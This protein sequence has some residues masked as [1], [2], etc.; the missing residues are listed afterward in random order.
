M[1]LGIE[2][3]LSKQFSWTGYTKMTKHSEVNWARFVDLGKKLVGKPYNFGEEVNLKDPDPLH[4]KAV[5]CSEL[6][7]WLFA[8]IGIVVPDG[9]YNQFKVS[10]TIAG[11]PI[12]GDLA[13]KW[14]PE[15]QSIHHVGVWVG[16]SVLEAKGKQ[17]GVVL[18]PRTEFEKSS[19]FAMWR[20][21]QT[22]V[23]A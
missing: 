8:Q 23:D 5:D 16:D 12:I 19:H 21:L 4:I 1:D 9:S 2:I 11:D 3:R 10:N 7:E 17:W 22:I 18:T 20:R 13:F 6:V 14:I 15:T